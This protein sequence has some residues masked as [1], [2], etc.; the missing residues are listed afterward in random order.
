MVINCV[1]IPFW[2]IKKET[3]RLKLQALANGRPA[4]SIFQ[5]NV[6]DRTKANTKPAST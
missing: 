2:A 5:T 1:I 4:R 6:N 3:A